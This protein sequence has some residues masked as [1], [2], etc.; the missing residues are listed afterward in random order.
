MPNQ[1][2]SPDV[3]VKLESDPRTG[4]KCHACEECEAGANADSET[5]WEMTTSVTSDLQIDEQHI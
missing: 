2:S 3:A 4:A 5:I 1:M